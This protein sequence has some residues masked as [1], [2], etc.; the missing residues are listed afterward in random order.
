M[1]TV[2]LVLGF[3]KPL[4]GTLPPVN[5]Y[6]R[7]K[8][9]AIHGLTGR[10]LLGPSYLIVVEFYG[11]A[12]GAAGILAF[13]TEPCR[14]M[15]TFLF[16]ILKRHLYLLRRFIH[17]PF[18]ETGQQQPVRILGIVRLHRYREVHRLRYPDLPP[19]VSS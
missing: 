18:I 3:A 13:G 6:L 1:G 2:F 12:D 16:E 11:D 15:H 10:G 14:Q 8:L 4:S 5:S 19:L 7:P 17:V 9:N